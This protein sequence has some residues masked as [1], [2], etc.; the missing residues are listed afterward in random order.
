MNSFTNYSE[1]VSNVSVLV[2]DFLAGN[3]T[4]PNANNE[5]A[6]LNYLAFH[7]YNAHELGIGL[8]NV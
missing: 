6:Y 5:R 1:E 2:G 8:R 4:V 3:S 7:K